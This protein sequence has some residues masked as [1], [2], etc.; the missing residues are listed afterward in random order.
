MYEI[1]LNIFSLLFFPK[2]ADSA[3]CVFFVW[4]FSFYFDLIDFLKA[5]MQKWLHFL[6]EILKFYVL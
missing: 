2:V 3:I 6:Q 5:A 4:I 1:S